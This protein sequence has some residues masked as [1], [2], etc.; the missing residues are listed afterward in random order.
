M[1]ITLD[2]HYIE[3]STQLEVDYLENSDSWIKEKT[4][5]YHIKTDAT[6][7]SVEL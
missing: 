2:S 7:E 1:S 6:K 5:F 3:L 4:S